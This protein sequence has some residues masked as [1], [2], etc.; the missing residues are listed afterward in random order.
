LTKLLSS[1]ISL[2]LGR[3]A[4]IDH[5]LHEFDE[6][7][8]GTVHDGD[9]TGGGLTIDSGDVSIAMTLTPS[10]KSRSR[11]WLKPK[12]SRVTAIGHSDSRSH[13]YG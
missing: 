7:G 3:I 8:I 9:A 6:I 11:G 1:C 10:A 12:L 4:P 13:S 2:A 5:K